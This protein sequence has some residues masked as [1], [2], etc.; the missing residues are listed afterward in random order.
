MISRY[1]VEI[2]DSLHITGLEPL[3][4]YDFY[5]T[6]D[7]VD[8]LTN[9]TYSFTTQNFECSTVKNPRPIIVEFKLIKHA[10]TKI[11]F[12]Y[13]YSDVNNEVEYAYIEYFGSVN[14]VEGTT[15]TKAFE[16]FDVKAI[17][18]SNKYNASMMSDGER[19]A[20]YL[21]SQC[22]IAPDDYI[23]II[24]EPEIHLHPEWQLIFAE[25]IVLIQKEFGMHILLNTHSPYFLNAIQVFSKKYGNDA[26]SGFVNGVLAKVM[27]K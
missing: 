12:A 9:N 21:I 11:E 26:S 27:A 22:L 7:A 19:V 8:P 10:G 4:S 23:I 24:D 14:K 2:G 5:A 18:D 25:L 13:E 15:G 6:F 1:S 3:T 20:L 16:G 17:C